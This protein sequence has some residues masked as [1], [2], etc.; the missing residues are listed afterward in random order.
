MTRSALAAFAFIC[1]AGTSLPVYPQV[2]EPH[3]WLSNET[4]KTRFRRF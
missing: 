1:T 4:L 2:T 3:G